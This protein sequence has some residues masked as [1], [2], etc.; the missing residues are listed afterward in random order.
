MAALPFARVD[1]LARAI[2]APA[3]PVVNVARFLG[4]GIALVSL[5][6]TDGFIVVVIAMLARLAVGLLAKRQ[7]GGITGDVLGATQQLAET[8]AL[9]AVAALA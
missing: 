6:V 8:A 1:G 7:L 2:G 5:G 4:T 9:L 3:S